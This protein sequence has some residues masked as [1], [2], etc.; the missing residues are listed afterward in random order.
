MYNIRRTRCIL[1]DTYGHVVYIPG[2][3][4]IGGHDIEVE[5]QFRWIYSGKE[6]VYTNWGN[7]EPGNASETE[8][9]I[10]THYSNHKWL[11]DDCAASH[12]YLCEMK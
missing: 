5:G 2:A 7:N 11:D 10:S 9:C 12:Y 8:N 3:Y 6:L 1:I 4:W